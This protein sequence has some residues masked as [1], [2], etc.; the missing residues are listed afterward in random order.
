MMRWGGTA[1]WKVPWG[2]CPPRECYHRSPQRGHSAGLQHTVLW[3]RSERQS[4]AEL[5]WH[6]CLAWESCSKTFL[7]NEVHA[8]TSRGKTGG[9]KEAEGTARFG[10]RG[11]DGGISFAFPEQNVGLRASGSGS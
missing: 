2:P 7:I 11:R 8:Q 6:S 4:R 3:H 10:V 9:L 1:S 5:S